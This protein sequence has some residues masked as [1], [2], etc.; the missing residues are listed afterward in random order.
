MEMGRAKV[1]Q[2]IVSDLTTRGVGSRDSPFRKIT[3]CWTLEGELLGENDPLYSGRGELVYLEPEP[4]A[5]A[6][7]PLQVERK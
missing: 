5:A 3:Q 6:E 7:T 1:L 2:V 4:S